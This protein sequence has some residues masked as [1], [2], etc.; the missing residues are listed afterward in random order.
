M[1]EPTGVEDGL[2]MAEVWESWG[3]VIVVSALAVPLCVMVVWWRATT[4]RATGVG[5][6]REPIA[7]VGA[8]AGTLPWSWMVMTPVGGP[9]GVQ[10]VPLVDLYAV[11]HDSFVPAVVQIGGN[12]LVFAALGFFLPVRWPLGAAAVAAI[13]CAGSLTIEILQWTLRLGRVSS[14]DDILLNTAGA[15]LA[16][17]LS[18]P[19]W[20]PRSAMP[21]R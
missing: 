4:A 19:W 18:R 11:L 20:K 1:A 2:C 10:A 17:A 13:A 15:V 5:G 8:I 3:R 16:A 12:L 7:E 21:V 9:G 14:V 6:W